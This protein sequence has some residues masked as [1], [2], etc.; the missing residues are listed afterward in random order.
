MRLNKTG[1]EVVCCF[2]ARQVIVQRVAGRQH[3]KN[4]NDCQKPGD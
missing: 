2:C 4:C 3:W 1:D